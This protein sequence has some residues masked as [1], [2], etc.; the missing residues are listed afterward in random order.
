M[1]NKIL[2]ALLLSLGMGFGAS[3]YAAPEN[4][5]IA[6]GEKIEKDDCSVLDEAVTPSLSKGVFASIQCEVDY[7]LVQVA[8]CHE[9][10]RK[11]V[12]EITCAI[13]GEWNDTVQWN[14]SSCAAAG[15]TFET[16]ATGKGFI[17]TNAGGSIAAA[18]L[19]AACATGVPQALFK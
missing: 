12:E 7:N 17:G 3:T 16:A 6:I 8:A 19:G 1:K 4:I 11:K 15:D 10:G 2:T 14:D 9:S 18:D 13:I 5:D